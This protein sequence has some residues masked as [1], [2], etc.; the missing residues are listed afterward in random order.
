[1]WIMAFAVLELNG[2]PVTK[3]V[4]TDKVYDPKATAIARRAVISMLSPF[5]IDKVI[6]IHAQ[7]GS[8]YNFIVTD[9]ESEV[10]KKS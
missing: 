4:M 7:M 5:I 2:V 6:R 1:M 8:C 3:N 9:S 10:V